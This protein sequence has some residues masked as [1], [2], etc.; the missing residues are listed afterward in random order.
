MKNTKFLSVH[1][2]ENITWSLN[3][4][5]TMK[6]AQLHLHFLRRLRRA[7]LPPPILITFYIGTIESLL[8]SCITAW[9]GLCT[10]LDSVDVFVFVLCTLAPHVNNNN[11]KKNY[12]TLTLQ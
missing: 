9:L 7:H 11:K 8:S 10:Q 3:T 4:G 2:V 6:K 1:L 12:Y 5:S